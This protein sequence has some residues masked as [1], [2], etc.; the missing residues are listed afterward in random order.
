MGKEVVTEYDF[1]KA[2]EHKSHLL[3]NVLDMDS[4]CTKISSDA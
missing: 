4:L 2:G 3:M 1:V